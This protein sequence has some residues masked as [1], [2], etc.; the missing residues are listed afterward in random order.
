MSKQLV[1]STK[2]KGG[3]AGAKAGSGLMDSWLGTESGNKDIIEKNTIAATARF[4]SYDQQVQQSKEKK[5]KLFSEAF[6]KINA[7][8]ESLAVPLVLAGMVRVVENRAMVEEYE[9]E[10]VIT[11]DSDDEERPRATVHH[12][13]TTE[14]CLD[15]LATLPA[16]ELE[17]CLNTVSRH[18]LTW[19]HRAAGIWCFFHVECQVR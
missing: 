3:A 4:G 13:G 16:L 11:I 18:Y 8:L 1:A 7:P 12:A 6:D 2:R 9:S 19:E 15:A 10:Q 14:D 5:M 17:K